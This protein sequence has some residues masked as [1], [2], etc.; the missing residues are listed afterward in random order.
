MK[1]DPPIVEPSP[2]DSSDKS[3]TPENTDALNT[4]THRCLGSCHCAIHLLTLLCVITDVCV[5]KYKQKKNISVRILQFLA[6]ECDQVKVENLTVS[7]EI[8]TV[9]LNL[10]SALRDVCLLFSLQPLTTQA[11]PA[12]CVNPLLELLCVSD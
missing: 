7:F 11:W 2:Q 12:A 5:Y 8:L 9:P 4:S 3:P 1:A 10:N 6:F